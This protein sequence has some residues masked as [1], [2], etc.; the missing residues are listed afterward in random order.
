MIGGRVITTTLPPV[1]F[2]KTVRD[3]G[4]SRGRIKKL[5][6]DFKFLA[7]QT[8]QALPRFRQICAAD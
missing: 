2:G 7:A 4:E 3:P 1:G 6:I 5:E 8:H